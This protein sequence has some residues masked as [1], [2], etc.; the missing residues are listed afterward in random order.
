M[1]NC[2]YCQHAVTLYY[3]KYRCGYCSVWLGPGEVLSNAPNP[4]P[5]HGDIDNI[6][7]E[8]Q[9][10]LTSNHTV[11]TASGKILPTE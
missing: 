3:D 7:T 5:A 2:P 10:H 8:A 11:D 9:Q 4:T 6:S 1:K